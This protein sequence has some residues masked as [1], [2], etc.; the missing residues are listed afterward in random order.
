MY[1]FYW[2]SLETTKYKGT[3]FLIFIFI[4][5]WTHLQLCKYVIE[6]TVENCWNDKIDIWNL[7]FLY[8][9]KQEY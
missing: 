2:I 1:S 5:K 9:K 4:S 6:H 3:D 8:P 7:F